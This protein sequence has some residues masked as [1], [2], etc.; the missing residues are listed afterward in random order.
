MLLA[1]LPVLSILLEYFVFHG[2]ADWVFLIGRWFVFWAG[3]VRLV[4]AGARQ[5]ANPA[6]TASTIFEVADPGANRIVQELGFGNLSIGLISL[7]SLFIPGW[8]EPAA[9]AS[10]L[11]YGLAGSKHVLNAKRNRL[12]TIATASDLAVAVVLLGFFIAAMFRA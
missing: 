5:V 1:V 7:V 11:Y 8:L 2:S 12:E 10:G 6:F 9:L 4:L 3:G